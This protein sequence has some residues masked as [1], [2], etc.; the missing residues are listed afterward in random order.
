MAC[1]QVAIACKSESSESKN[2]YRVK[3]RI[4]FDQSDQSDSKFPSLFIPNHSAPSYQLYCK[5]NRKRSFQGNAVKIV[6]KL[7]ST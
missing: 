1:G 3:G 4:P 7:T 2:E 5:L 6:L